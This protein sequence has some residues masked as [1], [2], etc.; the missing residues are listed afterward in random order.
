[1][2]FG[3]VTNPII[4]FIEETGKIPANCICPFKD[5]CELAIF[6]VCLHKGEQHTVPFSCGAARAFVIT[7]SK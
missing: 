1:M 3:K 7:H 2:E 5:E 6:N 4:K